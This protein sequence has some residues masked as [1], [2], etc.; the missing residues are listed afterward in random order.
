MAINAH[1]NP[2]P[3]LRGHWLTLARL[4]WIIL[5]VCSL[6]IFVIGTFNQ[7]QKPLPSCTAR[8]ADCGPWSISREDI[9]LGQQLGIREQGLFLLA[10]VGMWFPRLVMVVIAGIIFWRK[11]SDWVALIISLLLMIATIEGITEVGALLPLQNALYSLASIL[12]VL[13]PFVFPNGRFVPRWTLWLTLPLALAYI[14]A[15]AVP[16]YIGLVGILVFSVAAYAVIYRYKRIFNAVERQQTK[17]VMV[18]FLST[19]IAIIPEIIILWTF[20]PEH[21]TPERL[22]FLFLVFIPVYVAVSLFLPICIGIAIFRYRLWDIDIIINRTLVYGALTTITIGVYM[23]LVGGLGHFFHSS[24]S[25]LFSLFA[26]GLIAIF[27]QPLRER[28]QRAVNRLLYGERDEPFSVLTKL[29][30]R[31]EVTAAPNA[32]FPTI[33]ESISQALRIP[34]V[35]IMLKEGDEFSLAAESGYKPSS[36]LTCERF[37][38]NYQHQP[39]GQILVSKR[40]GEDSFSAGDITLLENIAHQV[41]VAAYA[42]QVTR[43]L[44]RSRERLVTAREEERRRLRRDLHDGLGPSLASLT[45]K[46]D[47]ARNLLKQDPEHAD[48]L[49]VELKSRTQSAIADVR[50][51]VYNLRPP[52]LDELGLFSAVQEY[53]AKINRPGFAVRVER[54]SDFPKLSAAVEVAAYRIVC[55]AISNASKHSQGTECSVHLKFDVGLRIDI[56]DNGVG[57]SQEQRV[58]VGMLS[59]R[60]RAAELGGTFNVESKNG[61]HISA[62]LPC[63]VDND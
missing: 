50:R 51:L 58:G 15:V 21:P 6:I 11:S 28:L 43:D 32:I 38:L 9:Q 60:E 12:F 52:A 53:A 48:F 63:E 29:G 17:W 3:N 16:K 8:G 37:P 40:G 41:S 27:F 20:P 34:Y 42:V 14:F 35:A 56:Q 39:I 45:L 36:T 10:T 23:L 31:L 7:L 26:T 61:V 19:T 59:M 55:E 57:L 24:D 22:A 1:P 49:L 5:S 18:G 33:T 25:L 62:T 2:E 54:D 30:E 4:V 44:Q 46:L 47:A 13:I